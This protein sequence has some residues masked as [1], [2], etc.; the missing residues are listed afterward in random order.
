MWAGSAW[1]ESH[2]PAVPETAPDT[3]WGK[4]VEIG[5]FLGFC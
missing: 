4:L 5:A 1:L 2:N 3:D